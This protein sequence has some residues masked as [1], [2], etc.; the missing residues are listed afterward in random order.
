MYKVSYKTL[1]AVQ[2]IYGASNISLKSPKIYKNF[3]NTLGEKNYKKYPSNMAQKCTQKANPFET[4][5]NSLQP[6]SYQWIEL[7]LLQKKQ[8]SFSHR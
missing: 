4:Q 6:K 1:R 2:L 7:H 3:P 5:K 8:P